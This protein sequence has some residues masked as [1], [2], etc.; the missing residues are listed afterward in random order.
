MP[1]FCELRTPRFSR[2]YAKESKVLSFGL[3]PSTEEYGIWNERLRDALVD[4]SDILKVV[5][6]FYNQQNHSE[7]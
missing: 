4:K 6:S 5:G 3:I 2:E 7:H 1:H